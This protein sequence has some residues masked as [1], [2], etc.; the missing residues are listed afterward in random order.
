M[1]E[2]PQIIQTQAQLTAAI[3]VVATHAEMRTVMGPGFNELL[4]TLTKLGVTPTGSWLNHHFRMPT[5]TFDFE[6]AIP[7]KETVP[8]TGR[9]KMS[10]LPATKAARTV[11]HGGY[12]GLGNAW[13]EFTAWAKANDL[14]FSG[15]FWEQYTVGPEAGDPSNYRTELTLPLID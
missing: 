15:E 8:A 7:V 1:I 14:E 5:D 11:Y 4:S 10:Q 3:P 9:V 13:G 12:E 6:I 2:T